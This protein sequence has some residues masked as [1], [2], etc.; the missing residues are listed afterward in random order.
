MRMGNFEGCSVGP[1]RTPGMCLL[2]YLAEKFGT[3]VRVIGCDFI[4]DF[5]GR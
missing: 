3:F 5:A 1:K 2:R 4:V